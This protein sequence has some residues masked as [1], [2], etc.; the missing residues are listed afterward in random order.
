MKKQGARSKTTEGA[1]DAL[2]DTPTSTTPA[3]STGSKRQLP[4]DFSRHSL[5]SNHKKI[6]P[7][8]ATNSHNPTAAASFAATMTQQLVSKSTT[9]T[10]S[11]VFDPPIIRVNLSTLITSVDSSDSSD[12]NSVDTRVASF[13]G[14][15]GSD[16]PDNVVQNDNP[17]GDSE[18][19]DALLRTNI[20]F[21]R[22]N[23]G[24]ADDDNASTVTIK[25]EDED[26]PEMSGLL[27]I[28]QESHD[29]DRKDFDEAFP[30]EFRW[31]TVYVAAF[32]L[33][34]DTV[35]P[36]E[37]FLFTDEELM[38]FETYRALAGYWQRQC[39]LEGRYLEIEDLSFALQQLF[40]VGLL[41]DQSALHDPEEALVMLAMDELKILARRIGVL[42]KL[43]GKRVRSV[44]D[45]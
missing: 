22:A 10:S 26:A 12:G 3:P 19:D 28:K 45:E 31:R 41:M 30:P 17:Y 4:L 6:S 13:A 7:P 32:E 14:Q 27:Q 9:S 23:S 42:E 40:S 20:R 11:S 25:T 2:T 37:A 43:S 15:S 5:H 39:K 36:E 29:E 21:G 1:P 18:T 44:A 34:L 33:A 8:A 24:D 38:L 35:L 16:S